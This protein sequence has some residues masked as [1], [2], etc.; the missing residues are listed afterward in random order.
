MTHRIVTR[1]LAASCSALAVAL[2]LS[3]WAHGQTA[4]A[5]PVQAVASIGL[6][7]GDADAE[8]EFF[9][10]VLGFEKLSDTERSG[11]SLEH[12]TGVFASRCR[13]VRLRLGE[14]CVELNQFLAPAGRPVPADSRSNDHWFQHIAIVVSDMDRAYRQLREHRV[15]HASS[16]PQTLPAWNPDAG[17]ISAFYFKD[18]ED[19]VL[20]V[21]HFPAGK[22]EA[23]WQATDK[24]FLGVDHTA[25]VVESTDRSLSFY[26]DALGMRVAGSSENYGTEQEHLNAVFGARLRVTALRADRGPGIELLEYLAPSDGRRYPSETTS[27]DLIN[28]TTVL[29]SPEVEST[30]EGLRSS[31]TTWVSPGLVQVNDGRF[32]SAMTV[33]DPDGHALVL[34]QPSEPLAS[35]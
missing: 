18:P 1:Q 14:E 32:R 35:H 3:S 8:A 6:S 21:I 22:G 16:G 20:E 2:G 23:R 12:L 19:H 31:R 28:W 27:A 5:S 7:V 24:L 9:T 30:A 11:D 29:V 4:H 26:R 33:R 25:I 10:T 15:R 17:G 13:V 34:G